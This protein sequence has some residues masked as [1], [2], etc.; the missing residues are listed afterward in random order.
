M[1]RLKLKVGGVAVDRAPPENQISSQP[2][3]KP[4]FSDFDIFREQ[5]E[6]RLQK[7]RR[8]CPLGAVSA[9]ALQGLLRSSLVKPPPK[10]P[11]EKQR[12]VQSYVRVFAAGSANGQLAALVQQVVEGHYAVHHTKKTLL[13]EVL[14]A[15]AVQSPSSAAAVVSPILS[16]L[17]SKVLT[18]GKRTAPFYALTA[19][20]TPAGKDGP[21]NHR[22]EACAVLVEQLAGALGTL[23]DPGSD[24]DADVVRVGLLAW[25]VDCLRT[26]SSADK[27]YFMQVLLKLNDGWV[28]SVLVPGGQDSSS[29][30]PL[31]SFWLASS[32]LPWLVD[33][34]TVPSTR[35]AAFEG[36]AYVLADTDLL[37]NTASHAAMVPQPKDEDPMPASASAAQQIARTAGSADDASGSRSRHQQIAAQLAK[38][39]KTLPE[40]TVQEVFTIWACALQLQGALL[41]CLLAAGEGSAGDKS[42]QAINT[43]KQRICQHVRQLP[44]VASRL[45][46]TS[47]EHLRQLQGPL[48]V[49]E[50]T[51]DASA[52]SHGGR[53]H[54]QHAINGMSVKAASAYLDETLRSSNACIQALQAVRS[55]SKGALH[56]PSP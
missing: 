8:T 23:P 9:L 34:L 49:L 31:D 36:L 13:D 52:P 3:P 50:Q 22:L 39:L 29:P 4:T 42:V 56:E 12:Q 41:A 38:S 26:A 47:Q 32:F 45:A 46:V 27:A 28:P 54:L 11:T 33:C 7:R 19:A 15:L 5:P 48:Q 2:S 14:A 10:K 21:W 24:Q 40:Q 1:P 53:P 35:T 16:L 51:L 44:L 20:F 17:N 37:W 43:C 55:A 30:T 18:Y 25:L 6:Q